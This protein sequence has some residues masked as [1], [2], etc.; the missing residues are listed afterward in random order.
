AFTSLIR[1][2]EIFSL[3]PTPY[4]PLPTPYSLL[5]APYSLSYLPPP[6]VINATIATERE[7]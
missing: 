3:L 5:P 6:R 1:C 4:S 2:I 7:Q